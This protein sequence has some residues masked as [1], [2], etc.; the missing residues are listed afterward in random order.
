MTVYYDPRK[1]SSALIV[2]L[3]RGLLLFQTLCLIIFGGGALNHSKGDAVI[4]SL[5]AD[6][7]QWLIL[8]L[9]L[10]TVLTTGL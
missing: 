4:G 6:A 5:A 7:S 2:M 8:S 1:G 9:D 3:S 10:V